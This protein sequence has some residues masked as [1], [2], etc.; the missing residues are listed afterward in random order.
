MADVVVEITGDCPLI[1][2]WLVEQ[3]IQT[4]KANSAEYVSNNHI[5]TYP[6]GMDVQVFRLDT[7]KTSASM[8][9]EQL[10]HEHV[11]LYIRNNPDLFSQIHLPAPPN[12]HWPELGLTLD[13][14][15][16]YQLI[17][18]IIEHF[19]SKGTYY[20]LQDI[21]DLLKAKPEWVEINMNVLRKGDA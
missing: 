11:T 21:I 3:C 1:D 2:P 20:S 5:R 14:E 16:D 6:D 17:K 9:S 12:L 7:L 13:E 4:F 8:T 10:D 18:N 19:A 15:A